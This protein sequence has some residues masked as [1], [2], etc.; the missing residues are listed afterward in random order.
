MQSLLNKSAS[1]SSCLWERKFNY[2]HKLRI[3]SRRHWG[4]PYAS[5]I[6]D[7]YSVF[8]YIWLNTLYIWFNI[9][10]MPLVWVSLTGSLPRPTPPVLTMYPLSTHIRVSRFAHM[11]KAEQ[12][13]CNDL[14]SFWGSLFYPARE[15]EHY[16]SGSPSGLVF[17]HRVGHRVQLTA[18][19]VMINGSAVCNIDWLWQDFPYEYRSIFGYKQ[20]LGWTSY[21]CSSI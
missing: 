10:A 20:I 21:G 13:S 3:C 2:A 17:S 14:V 11:G 12:A 8:D 18:S 5:F 19:P 16:V 7:K 9:C 4:S 6:R 1:V 15:C